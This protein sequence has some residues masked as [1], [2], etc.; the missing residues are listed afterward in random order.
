MTLAYV[1]GEY[2]RKR[3]N[4]GRGK[5]TYGQLMNAM[6]ERKIP[7]ALMANAVTFLIEH[8]L[9]R[10]ECSNNAAGEPEIYVVVERQ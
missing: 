5:V 1:V 7:L 6:E 10:I 4:A 2:L 8:D 9:A 3:L